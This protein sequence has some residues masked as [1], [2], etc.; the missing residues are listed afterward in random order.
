MAKK[1]L[2]LRAKQYQH[3]SIYI[4]YQHIVFT[5]DKRDSHEQQRNSQTHFFCILVSYSLWYNYKVH[6]MSKNE[7]SVSAQ[8]FE[9]FSQL[10]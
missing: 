7:S 10:K 3:F 1:G 9:L 2:D 6:F 4:D 5:P 8:C